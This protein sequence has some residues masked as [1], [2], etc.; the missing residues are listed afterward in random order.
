MAGKSKSANEKR[1]KYVYQTKNLVNDKTYIGYHCTN[2]LSDGYIGCGCRSLSYAKSS[3]KHGLK[4]AFLRS[5]VKHGYE[6]FK[7]EILSFYDTVEECLEEEAFLVDKK[8]VNAKDNYNVKV[9]GVGNNKHL[10][11]TTNEED[12]EI[13]KEFMNGAYKED[14]CKKYNV[15]ESVIYRITKNKDVSNRIVPLQKHRVYINKW[16]KE[17]SQFYIEKYKNWEMTKEEINKQIPFYLWR[18]DFLLGIEQNKKYVCEDNFGNKIT[19]NTQKEISDI[20]GVTI[21]RTGFISVVEGKYK[22][23]KQYK[24]YYNA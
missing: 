6:N 20:L 24:F 4:S 7:K 16:I 15:S 3:V 10:L 13:F 22:Q 1:Y 23:Y 19:F 14:L 2:D 12:E 18:N 9:G 5:V 11:A 17:N 8:W 21:H